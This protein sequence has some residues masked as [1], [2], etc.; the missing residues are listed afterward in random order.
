MLFVL[1]GDSIFDIRAMRT[2]MTLL[3]MRCMCLCVPECMCEYCENAART[4][5]AS[6]REMH[7]SA[8]SCTMNIGWKRQC[9]VFDICVVAFLF[10][11]KWISLYTHRS[12][13][14]KERFVLLFVPIHRNHVENT[15]FMTKRTTLMCRICAMEMITWK[16]C[17]YVYTVHITGCA[18]ANTNTHQ[19]CVPKEIYDW[20]F[21]VSRCTRAV[22]RMVVFTLKILPLNSRHFFES[23]MQQ[24]VM[25]KCGWLMYGK[26]NS[27]KL[28]TFYYHLND[29]HSSIYTHTEWG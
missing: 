15:Y 3:S 26:S 17:L 27:R 11:C 29:I 2:R 16:L 18:H 20:H 19:I 8:P 14:A 25:K 22:E 24:E 1:C 10:F 7:D 5:D 13:D 4:R 28:H 23:R 21:C 6:F 9:S 12:R